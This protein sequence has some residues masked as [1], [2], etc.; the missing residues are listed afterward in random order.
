MEKGQ[1]ANWKK[2]MCISDIGIMELVGMEFFARHGCLD[3]EQEHGNLFTVD[4][5]AEFPIGRSAESDLL[6]DTVDYSAIYNLIKSEM[7]VPSKLLEHV[8][9]R[10]CRR[11]RGSFPQLGKF[12][13]TVS[14]RNPPVDGLC[15]WARVK[16][17][18][19]P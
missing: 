19:E 16:V 14:K 1:T 4:F 10:I 13:I 18:D 8:A 5:K 2:A 3:F 15:R 7:E 17:T 11:I 12:E 9:A 6:E